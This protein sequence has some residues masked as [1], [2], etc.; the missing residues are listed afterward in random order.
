MQINNDLSKNNLILDHSMY[1]IIIKKLVP[2]T[3]N[4][5]FIYLYI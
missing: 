1:V 3:F 2:E 5:T 4:P